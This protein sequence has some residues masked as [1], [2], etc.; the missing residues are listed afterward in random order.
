MK[1]FAPTFQV[2]LIS[3]V[4]VGK[5]EVRFESQN[6][7]VE[8]LGMQLVEDMLLGKLPLIFSS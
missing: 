4:K 2:S 8:L 1:Y 7:A 3:P 5:I 6:S